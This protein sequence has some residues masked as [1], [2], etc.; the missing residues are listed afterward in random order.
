MDVFPA[1]RAAHSCDDMQRLFL[2]LVLQ[3]P[4]WVSSPAHTPCAVLMLSHSADMRCF[5]F[6]FGGSEGV[7]T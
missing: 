3:A 7:G 4:V 2:L 5:F 6:L 1:Y